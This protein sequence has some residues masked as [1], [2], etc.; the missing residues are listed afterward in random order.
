MYLHLG[1]DFIVNTRDVIGVFDLDTATDA[2]QKLSLIHIY[3]FCR[4]HKCGKIP[5]FLSGFDSAWRG[6][7]GMVGLYGCLL[8]TSRCV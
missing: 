1:Q 4:G 3:S 8:Y 5:Y 6:S 2:G 7:S